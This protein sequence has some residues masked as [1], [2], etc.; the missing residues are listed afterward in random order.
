MEVSTEDS[1]NSHNSHSRIQFPIILIHE[2]YSTLKNSNK[3]A[4]AKNH[5][6]LFSTINDCKQV[7]YDFFRGEV[8]VVFI[9]QYLD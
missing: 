3:S 5:Y 6:F 2:P 1:E 7:K 9:G 8:K 4:I